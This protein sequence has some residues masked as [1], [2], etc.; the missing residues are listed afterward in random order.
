MGQTVFSWLRI[1]SVVGSCE[2]GNKLPGSIKDG[3][4]L[5]WLSDYQHLKKDF[6]HGVSY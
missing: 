6:A 4:F 5:K 2:H 1:G 3:S